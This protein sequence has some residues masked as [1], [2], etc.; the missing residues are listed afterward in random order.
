MSLIEND[1][2]ILI[3]PDGNQSTRKPYLKPI[4]TN[5]FELETLAGSPMGVDPL[6]PNTWNSSNP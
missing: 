2:M 1:A 6:D 3:N 4:I 5:E